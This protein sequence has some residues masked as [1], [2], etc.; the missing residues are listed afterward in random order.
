MIV[1]GPWL[2]GLGQGC[3]FYIPIPLKG[4]LGLGVS[5]HFCPLPPLL[6]SG[7]FNF[8]FS[9]VPASLLPGDFP[10]FPPEKFVVL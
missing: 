8:M 6:S 1:V 3:P 10:Y 5:F 9:F 7:R 2:L 4:L